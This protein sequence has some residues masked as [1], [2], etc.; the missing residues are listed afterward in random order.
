MT[1]QITVYIPVAI[2]VTQP[3]TFVA[4]FA[5][6]CSHKTIDGHSRP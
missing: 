5:S 2:A 1:A 4:S 3:T 6:S